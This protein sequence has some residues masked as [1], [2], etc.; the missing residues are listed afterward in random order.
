MSKVRVASKPFQAVKV[1][2]VTKKYKC[3][4][5]AGAEFG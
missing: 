2:V 4:G 1:E 3:K 5:D